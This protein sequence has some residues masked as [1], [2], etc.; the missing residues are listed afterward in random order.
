MLRDYIAHRMEP[1]TLYITE[2]LHLPMFPPHAPTFYIA[3]ASFT[4][5]HILAP[6]FSTFFFPTV[7]PNLSRRV[8]YSWS[9]HIVSMCN[10]VAV[11]PWA[12]YL[13]NQK[14]PHM[15]KALGFD[16]RF[17]ELQAVGAAYFVWDTIETILS[18]SGIAFTLH[19]L[20]YGNFR[21]LSLTFIDK[22][23]KTGTRVQLLNGI[24]LLVTFFSARIVYG[25]ITAYDLFMTMWAVRDQVPPVLVYSY[26]VGSL[27]LCS[28]NLFWFTKM[29]AALQKRFPDSKKKDDPATVTIDG[30]T[31]AVPKGKSIKAAVANGK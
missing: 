21:R 19:E 22:A 7:Y 2:T 28:L 26:L 5:A 30:Q 6:W 14:V 17:G 11:V 4:L 31:L 15:H 16:E 3:F 10:V 13:V 29:V 24:A 27:A 18:G 23:G 1:V 12:L 20:F 25:N 8:R 9:V